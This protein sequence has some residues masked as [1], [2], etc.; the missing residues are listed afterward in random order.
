[1]ITV[2]PTFASRDDPYPC[3]ISS[4]SGQCPLWRE[5]IEVR[6]TGAGECGL[7]EEPFGEVVHDHK[8]S[9]DREG[10]MAGRG[11]L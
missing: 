4:Y 2:S 8:R 3:G 5:F 1:M 9:P 11:A 10:L 6:D 7:L